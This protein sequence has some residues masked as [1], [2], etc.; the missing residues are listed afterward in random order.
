MPT[1]G[2]SPNSANFF[3]LVREATP[4]TYDADGDRF[5]MSSLRVEP[6][7]ESVYESL[8]P[9]G[10]NARAWNA[11]TREHTIISG[12]V[13][14][15]F[16]Q[17]DLLLSLLCGE[18]FSDETSGGVRTRVYRLK[19]TGADERVV[20]TSEFGTPAEAS[21]YPY[22]LLQALALNFMRMVETNEGTITLLARRP[23]ADDVTLTGSVAQN[24]IFVVT[25][26]NV[27]GNAVITFPPTSQGEGGDVEIEPGDLASDIDTLLQLTGGY[28]SVTV[29]GST[30]AIPSGDL[31]TGLTPTAGG[32][33]SSAGNLVDNNT[34]SATQLD[35]HSTKALAYA[36][37]DY[38]QFDLG[39]GAGNH[40]E[41]RSY[42]ANG[43]GTLRLY[44]SATGAFAG[45]EVLVASIVTATNG[46]WE[47]ATYAANGLRY[48]RIHSEGAIDYCTVGEI[49]IISAGDS[50]SSGSYTITVNTPQ[51]QIALPEITGTGW[52]I[53]RTQSG[54][55][56]VFRV[57]EL[58]PILP[59]MWTARRAA[60]YA[61]LDG[62][63][64]IPRVKGFGL[65][66]PERALLHWFFNENELDFSDWVQ[67]EGEVM[68]RV[69][70]VNDTDGVCADLHTKS[71]T[72]PATPE[73]WR[74]RAVHPEL[75]YLL[76][77]DGNFAVAGSIPYGN[78]DNVRHREF[79]LSAMLN[80]QGWQL[81]ITTEVPA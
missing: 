51:E 23:T 18:P 46:V 34:G 9:Q 20:Y 72:Q 25:A 32:G 19:D 16:A 12:A 5:I 15:D 63:T 67:G 52:S 68:A 69:T 66:L 65:D 2:L 41:F 81:Q 29:T 11:I 71:Q 64:A 4:G 33:V 58:V 26:T 10:W 80:D 24:T 30:P 13:R 1:S 78:G 37:G 3:Q 21:R 28:P 31:T 7:P 36:A 40:N 61:G 74:F 39:A 27:S 77:I 35:N 57:P 48:V 47:N 76:Q 14:L 22:T 55:S 38:V 17:M 49:E 70:I 75:D 42:R 8:K 62:A 59:Q 54:S 60:S 43:T 73:W 50:L 6:Q 53:E 79:P 45:E 44:G 56:G